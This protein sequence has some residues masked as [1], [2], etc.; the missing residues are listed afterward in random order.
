VNSGGQPQRPGFQS[1][2]SK[3]VF[4]WKPTLETFGSLDTSLDTEALDTFDSEHLLYWQPLVNFWQPHQ[5][6]TS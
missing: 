5:P 4:T 1:C 2:I 6:E 3:G